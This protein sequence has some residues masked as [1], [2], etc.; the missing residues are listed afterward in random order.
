MSRTSTF[1]GGFSVTLPLSDTSAT[2][3]WREF[4]LHQE[5]R[6]H[7]LLT[8]TVRS[9]ST[10]YFDT[11]YPNTPIQVV[12][13]DGDGMSAMFLGYVSKVAPVTHVEDSHYEREIT[14][15]AA[16]REF[17]ATA[18][19]T[20][21]NHTA[22]EIA[23]DIGKRLGFKVVTK[24]HG[25]RK[26]QIVQGGE[27]YWEVLTKLAKTTGYVLR[28]EGTTLYFLPLKEM[29][30]AFSSVAPILATASVATQYPTTVLDVDT[31]LGN[32]SD[33]ED[34]ESDTAVVVSLG[35]NDTEPVAVR[36]SPRSAV[37]SSKASIPAYEKYNPSIIAH[38]RADAQLLAKGMADQGM[39]AYDGRVF[40]KGD[41]FIAP[42]RPVY[43]ATN[44]KTA[45]GYWI[46]KSV[47]H[48]ITRGEYTCE[49]IISTDEVSPQRSVPPTTRYRNLA[50]EAQ[51][52]WSPMTGS[53]SR[54]KIL[55]PSFVVGMTYRPDGKVAQWVAV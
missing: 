45:T 4:R 12:Y 24:Q 1:K 43:L 10:E 55:S 28:A 51:Q 13:R 46:V 32:T 33:D 14:C 23:Q 25:L 19:N 30:K 22:P 38:S 6:K 16:S 50:Q 36:E 17:R 8:L 47:T 2:M 18:R 20:W 11:L 49:T 53:A 44:D 15:V 41:P 54:L 34:D 31:L 27:T 7:D 40:G 9:R 39:M 35:P 37:R 52:G 29:I 42:Y 5:I 3:D 21:R 48:R 26:K